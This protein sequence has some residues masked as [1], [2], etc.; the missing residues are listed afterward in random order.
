MIIKENFDTACIRKNSR[1]RLYEG[2]G[3]TE[4]LSVCA[5][6]T[7]RRHKFASIGYPL[8]GVEIKI[9]DEDRKELP[10]YQVG[11]IAIKCESNMLHYFNDPEATKATYVG[12]FLTTGDLGYLDEDGFLYFKSRKKNVIKVSGVAVFPSE[13]E[14][15]ISSLKGVTNCCVVQ[16]PDEKTVNAAKAYVVSK[17]KD[18]ERIQLACKKKLI[19]WAIPKEVEFVSSLPMT[20]Y[21]KVDHKKVQEMENKKRNI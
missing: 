21:N 11:E 16:I 13:I 15:V 14:K 2:Y 10:P 17:N 5:V 4:L 1:C 20:K 8:R 9:L 12:D 18:P 6:N 19:S 3:L 7:H